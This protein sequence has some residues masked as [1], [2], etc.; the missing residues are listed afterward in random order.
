MPQADLPAKKRKGNVRNAFSVTGASGYD[1]VLLIDDVITT[2]STINE[3]ARMLS[4]AGVHRIDV[5]A[6][7]RAG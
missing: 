6:V 5:L 3:L 1:H 7:A 4:L 2:G